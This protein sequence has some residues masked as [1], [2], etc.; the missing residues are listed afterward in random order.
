[1]I[2]ELGLIFYLNKMY[3]LGYE[4]IRSSECDFN[5]VQKYHRLLE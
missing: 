4:W 5:C 2:D 1:M 3:I